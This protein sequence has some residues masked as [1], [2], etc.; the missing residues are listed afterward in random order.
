[1]VESTKQ[2]EADGL[3]YPRPDTL[4]AVDVTD[5]FLFDL[6]NFAIPERH[7]PYLDKVI[8]PDGFIKNRW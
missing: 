2:V 8:L 6:D 1:M 7:L 5:A 4:E 3:Y